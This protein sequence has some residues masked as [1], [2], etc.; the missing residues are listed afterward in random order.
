MTHSEATLI[1]LSDDL[2]HPAEPNRNWRESYHFSFSDLASGIFGYATFG[3]RPHTG[4]SGFLITLSHPKIGMLVGQDIDR[5]DSHDDQ[6]DVA[7]LRVNCIRPFDEWRVRFDGYL[8]QVPPLGG[9]R[10]EEARAVPASERVQIAVSLDFTWTGVSEPFVYKPE[11]DFRPLFGGRYEQ[12]GSSEG[13]LAIDG[14]GSVAIA[15]WQGVRD[16]AWGVRDWHA[17]V[18]WRW[19][20]G[21]FEQGPH[22]SMLQATLGGGRTVRQGA[23]YW[24]RRAVPLKSYSE[25]LVEEASPD[26]PIPTSIDIVARDVEG[27]ELR[28]SG[29]VR[30]IVPIRFTDSDSG[31][32]SWNDRSI[33][34]FDG[35]AGRGLGE[36]EFMSFVPKTNQT[37]TSV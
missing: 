17:V 11:K 21:T 22:I 2:V 15:G 30:G 13:S 24:G 35:S 37:V 5:F 16:H 27:G 6:H 18:A 19:I 23:L 26:K 4:R 3:K 1:E 33:V 36:V 34:D 9:V 12:V 14:L 28:A 29:R 31:S 20:S 10:Y 7:G 32:V 8:T 25:V